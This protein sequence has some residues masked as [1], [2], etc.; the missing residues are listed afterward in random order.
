MIQCGY[1]FF[2]LH[3]THTYETLELKIKLYFE[4]HRNK[5]ALQHLFSCPNQK[6]ERDRAGC[7]AQCIIL[8][9][10]ESISANSKNNKIT[11]KC[12]KKGKKYEAMESNLSFISAHR[13]YFK[14]LGAY[15]FSRHSPW[16]QLNEVLSIWQ[17]SC[18]WEG[19]WHRG[20]HHRG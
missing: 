16:V 4:K 19:S 3:L 9:A 20:V 14:S 13:S 8:A 15:P 6:R 11:L 5:R 18:P 7:G 10:E 2:Y 17:S 1:N 12:K